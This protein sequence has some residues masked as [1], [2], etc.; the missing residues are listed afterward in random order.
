[1]YM[2]TT[3]SDYTTVVSYPFFKI[4][5]GTANNLGSGNSFSAYFS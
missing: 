4:K 5:V 3:D 1:M 2:Y